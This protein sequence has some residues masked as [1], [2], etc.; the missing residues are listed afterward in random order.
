[1]DVR[2]VGLQWTRHGIPSQPFVS[3]Y[4]KDLHK[5]TM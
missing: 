3:A 5:V 4:V 2:T 1:M